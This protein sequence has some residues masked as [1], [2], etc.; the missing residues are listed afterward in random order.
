M[1]A[2]S[3][4]TTY[5]VSGGANML[6][7]ATCTLNGQAVD[8]GKMAGVSPGGLEFIFV[9]WLGIMFVSLLGMIFWILMLVHA[10]TKPIENKAL[11]VVIIAITGVL[12]AIVYYFAVKREFDDTLLRPQ[13]PTS[14]TTT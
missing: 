8:C 14:V 13:N 7:V 5:I 9:I 11:W 6:A 1:E 4:F 2:V 10:A 3:N 12:G